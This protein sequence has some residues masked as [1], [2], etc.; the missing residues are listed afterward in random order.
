[1]GGKRLIVHHPST[2]ILLESNEIYFKESKFEEAKFQK[3]KYERRNRNFDN[4]RLINSGQ[5]EVKRTTK[6]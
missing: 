6:Y 4:G 5:I 1:V 3:F 2:K